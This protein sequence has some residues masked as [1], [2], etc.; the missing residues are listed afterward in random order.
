MVSS[1]KIAFSAL[2]VSILS[3]GVSFYFQNKDRVKLKTSCK[4]FPA[5]PDYDHAHLKIKVVNCGRRPALLTLFGGDLKN[6]SWQGTSIGGKEKALRLGEHEFHEEEFYYEDIEAISPDS[7]SEYTE[8]W[9]E[10]SLGNR[11]VVKDSRE[12]IKLLHE[13]HVRI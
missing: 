7:E 6:G 9:F 1:D 4:F 13:S 10:D 8:L 11:H 12:G 5:H 2:M 3:L